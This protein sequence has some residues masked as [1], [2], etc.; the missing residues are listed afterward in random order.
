MVALT[1]F[2]LLAATAGGGMNL[3]L[4]IV[5]VLLSG[6]IIGVVVGHRSAN[7]KNNADARLAG[8]QADFTLQDTYQE[9]IEDQRKV[10]DDLR[11]QID[12]MR[13]Q[14][15]EL[16]DRARSAESSAADAR[17]EAARDRT[18]KAQADQR[19]AELEAE[20][21]RALKDAGEQ[22]HAMA[23]DIKALQLALQN[24]DIEMAELRVELDNLRG[25]VGAAE[26]RTRDA[27]RRGD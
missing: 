10:N 20:L 27:D 8:A 15:S 18:D 12:E 25:V 2:V 7:R 16:R 6:G 19:I 5:P 24:K 21:A 11:S 14:M 3:A 1:L 4:A 13:G 22:R 26:R 9:W 23:N 17:V